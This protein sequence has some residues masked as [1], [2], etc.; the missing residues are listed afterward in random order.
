MSGIC[1]IVRPDGGPVAPEDIAAMRDA[2]AYFGPDGIQTQARP[3][4]AFCH[5]LLSASLEDDAEIQ[6]IAEE[7]QLFVAAARLD[8]RQ[9][10]LADLRLRAGAEECLSDGRIVFEAHRRW[11]K[12]A[13]QHLCGDWQFAA[14]DAQEKSLF[15]ARD[16]FGNSA[17]FYTWDGKRL[18]FA[19][20]LHALLALRDLPRSLDMTAL[21]QVVFSLPPTSG[22]TP[23]AAIRVLHAGHALEF[24]GQGLQVRQ[25]WNP[26]TLAPI[27]LPRDE[28]YFEL[29]LETYQQAVRSRLRAKGNIA[30]TLSGGLDSGS[31]FALAAP[32]LRDLGKQAQAYTTI[33]QPDAALQYQ[34]TR[35]TNEWALASATAHFAGCSRHEAV[36]APRGEVIPS[37]H[38]M[39][40]IHGRPT[41]SIG[42]LHWLSEILLRVNSAGS[43][44]LMTGQYGNFTVS[45]TGT[46]SWVAPLLR[47]DWTGLKRALSLA[48]PDAWRVFKRHGA[49]PVLAWTRQMVN[50]DLNAQFWEEQGA[51]QPDFAREMV[52][53]LRNTPLARSRA[54]LLAGLNPQR[55][56]YFSS[57]MDLGCTH[58]HELGAA[59]QL[60]I[61]DPTADRRLIELSFQLPDDLFW[62]KGRQRWI[63]REVMKD[64][65]P[66]EVLQAPRKGIQSADLSHRLLEEQQAVEELLEKWETSAQVQQVLNL[67]QLKALCKSLAE[68]G[69]LTFPQITQYLRVLGVGE[70]LYQQ[71]K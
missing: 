66:E 45:Y 47:R 17:L 39:L 21:A 33:P 67:P 35:V 14:W 24:K 15:L 36:C 62:R 46:G 44:V 41:V 27:Y 68:V 38:K 34:D 31:V 60:E 26:D 65:M 32:L 3:E 28:D 1:G 53:R 2:M 59:H 37:L 4:A 57:G 40:E 63:L 61:R 43:R 8:N 49:K 70:F 6:P 9:E 10:L 16:H 55:S 22:T 69:T 23:Y 51:L 50:P 48:E 19:S 64:R 29:F 18:A 25:Y 12:E 42:T 30:F 54:N 56:L 5:F 20:S 13:P 11:A 71:D 58:W 52:S 7:H